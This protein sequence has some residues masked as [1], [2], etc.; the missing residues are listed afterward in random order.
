MAHSFWYIIGFLCGLAVVAIIGTIL[1]KRNGR[2]QYDERQELARG[3]AFKA[4]FFILLY[5]LTVTGILDLVWGIRFGDSFTSSF[6]GICLAAAVFACSCIRHDA[7]FSVNDKP[8]SMVT[9]FII[10]T[11]VNGAIGVINLL[12]YGFMP[13]GVLTTDSMNLICGAMS[14]VILIAILLKLAQDRRTVQ[15]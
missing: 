9:L 10:L 14:L 11:V 3:K 12:R 6:L 8:R 1:I 5:Y 4:A 7:Y 2:P 13:G 15:E